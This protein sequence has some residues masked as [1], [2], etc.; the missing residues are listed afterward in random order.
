MDE[1]ARKYIA[2][3]VED[4]HS[5]VRHGLQPFA[6]QVDESAKRN[7]PSA[8]QAIASFHTTLQQHERMLDQRMHGL[9]TSPTTAVQ[10]AAATLAGVVAGLYN[11][12]R[13]EAVSK[14]L[15]DDYTFL[16]H[17]SISWL[18]LMTTARALGD[19][20]TEEMAEQ[21]Y[22]DC[23]RMVMDI[24]RVMPGLVAEEMQQ[25]GLPAQDVSEWASGIVH[26][27]W[28]RPGAAATP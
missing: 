22:R 9:G 24:D 13:T 10:D 25:D 23:A 8:H 3:Y 5:L 28:T 17:C 19:H 15:R 14:S 20:D 1:N 6:R 2:K 4:L 16:S 27:A 26:N 7:H 18:M 12:V 21:G 11:Q